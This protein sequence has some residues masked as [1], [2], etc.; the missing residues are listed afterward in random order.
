M[1]MCHVESHLSLDHFCC[2]VVPSSIMMR[3]LILLMLSVYSTAFQPQYN[4]NRLGTRLFDQEKKEGAWNNSLRGVGEFFS[5]FDDVIDDF[6]NKRMGNG[7]VFYGKRKFKPSGRPNTE[8]KYSGMGMSDKA[9]IDTVREY[10]EEVMERQR[11][12]Q[13]QDY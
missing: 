11:Q 4:H 9:R 8:G 12:R 5:S 1:A 3:V 10:K 2:L 7:E 13:Q 6:M